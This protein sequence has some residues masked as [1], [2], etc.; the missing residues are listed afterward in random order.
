MEKLTL[1]IPEVAEALGISKAKAYELA[2]TEGFPLL[3]C[4]RKLLASKQGLIKWL[5]MQTGSE[6]SVCSKL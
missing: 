1:T 3:C 5:A 2:H 6:E 4:G